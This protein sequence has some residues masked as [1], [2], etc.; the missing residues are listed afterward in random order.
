MRESLPW[1]LFF[2]RVAFERDVMFAS[3][4]T[5]FVI[6]GK[7]SMFEERKN[8]LRGRHMDQ[9]TR[10]QE[11]QLT[12]LQEERGAYESPERVERTEGH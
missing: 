1:S 3:E 6:V 8:L 2:W 9:L 12:R 7:T 11:D 5:Q 10:L 4:L